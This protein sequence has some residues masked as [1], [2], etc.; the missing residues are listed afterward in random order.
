MTNSLN[1]DATQAE[2]MLDIKRER[3]ITVLIMSS[4]LLGAGIVFLI[5]WLDDGNFRDEKM[6]WYGLAMGIFG[7]LLFFLRYRWYRHHFHIYDDHIEVSTFKKIYRLELDSIEIDWP[8]GSSQLKISDRSKKLAGKSVGF[9]LSDLDKPTQKATVAYF[10]KGVAED[11]Q[12]N[13]GPFWEKNWRMFDEIDKSPDSPCRV[14][15]SQQIRP[16]ILRSL[17]VLLL[18]LLSWLIIASNEIFDSYYWE[19][20][21]M[22]GIFLFFTTAFPLIQNRKKQGRFEAEYLLKRSLIGL[23]N[24]NHTIFVTLVLYFIVISLLLVISVA[25]PNLIELDDRHEYFMY[26]TITIGSL[27]MGISKIKKQWESDARLEFDRN[28]AAEA[29]VYFEMG[30]AE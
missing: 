19:M 3:S 1:Q 8:K 10:R 16:A 26:F 24:Y 9:Y 29:E 5:L 17:P 12:K 15:Q 11:R 6:L 27:A 20:N 14:L 28:I 18:Y 23:D 21:I 30:R 2:L 25:F 4:Y 22:A 7:L 13:W